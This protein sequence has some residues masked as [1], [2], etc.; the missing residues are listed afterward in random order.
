MLSIVRTDAT[1][2]LVT[3]R[4]GQAW[5]GKCIHCNSKL[6]VAEH[7]ET[8]ATVEH[9]EPRTHGG[10]DAL[11]NVALACAR[12]NAGKGMRLD[13]RRRT[14]PTLRAVVEALR[15]KRAARWRDA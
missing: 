12:C 3:L 9:L 15:S 14:D 5:V 7:G 6:V 8:S 1:F 4:D 10:T 2:T 13:V 11:D